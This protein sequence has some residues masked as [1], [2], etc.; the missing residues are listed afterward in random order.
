MQGVQ[1]QMSSWMWAKSA[2]FLWIATRVAHII[3]WCKQ[4]F[5]SKKNCCRIYYCGW[6]IC[7]LK[8]TYLGSCWCIFWP[9]R[10]GRRLVWME[11]VGCTE[12]ALLESLLL[13]II[14]M[15]SSLLYG[16]ARCPTLS[17]PLAYHP[18]RL[19]N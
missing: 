3:C 11:V 13:T 10:L 5:P 12:E 4:V 9:N 16:S 19:V 18:S 7:T 8:Y 17:R 2:T 6:S 15:M 14:Q 1:L